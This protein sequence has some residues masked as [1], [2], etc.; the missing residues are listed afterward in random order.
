MNYHLQC[1]FNLRPQDLWFVWVG[2]PQPFG[3]LSLFRARARVLS[4][5]LVGAPRTA[6]AGRPH[7]G[8]KAGRGLTDQGD[9]CRRTE[10]EETAPGQRQTAPTCPEAEQGDWETLPQGKT[11]VRVTRPRLGGGRE[12][13]EEPDPARIRE[14]RGGQLEYGGSGGPRRPG[15]RVAV[16]DLTE[17][18]SRGASS[19]HLEA[20]SAGGSS[21]P[22]PNL[23]HVSSGIPSATH[24][25]AAPLPARDSTPR[26]RDGRWDYDINQS[27][28]SAGRYHGDQARLVCN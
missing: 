1:S 9:F 22:L 11:G 19:T 23:S 14:G 8:V 17:G 15:G 13:G 12:A 24:T 6:L 20:A 7:T 28:V 3:I 4:C 16:I 2:S 10:G 5:V 26:G 25:T 27:T 18:S 21:G